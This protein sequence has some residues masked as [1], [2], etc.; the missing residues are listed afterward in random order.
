VSHL[1]LFSVLDGEP[2]YILQGDSEGETAGKALYREIRIVIEMKEP[3]EAVKSQFLPVPA[4]VQIEL[5]QCDVRFLAEHIVPA[6]VTFP[7]QLAEHPQPLSFG[8]E[9]LFRNLHLKPGVQGLVIRPPN[10][11]GESFPLPF[12]IKERLIGG[13][14]GF[15][16]GM[17]QAPAGEQGL[18]DSEGDII[19]IAILGSDFRVLG[20]DAVSEGIA[21]DDEPHRSVNEGVSGI[22]LQDGKEAGPRLDH[23]LPRRRHI[24]LRRLQPPVVAQCQLDAFLKGHGGGTDFRRRRREKRNGQQESLHFRNFTITVIPSLRPEKSSRAM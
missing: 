18:L 5:R 20:R 8:R 17:R 11:K 3:P 10:P 19:E 21:V 14:P 1:Q 13:S 6:D 24:H 7:M 16:Q 2:A 22:E 15:P 9:Y 4:P 12:D 23:I